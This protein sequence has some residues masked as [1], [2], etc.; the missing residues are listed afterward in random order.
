MAGRQL[1]NRAKKS[2]VTP[3]TDR[4]QARFRQL[5]DENVDAIGQG[6]VQ[7]AS[8]GNYN[9]AQLLLRFSGVD[10]DAD[11]GSAAEDDRQHARIFFL[12]MVER[13]VAERPDSSHEGDKSR[14]RVP[15][16]LH[17]RDRQVCLKGNK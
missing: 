7:K 12:E 1:S 17:R 10:P 16:D 5:L 2:G 13:M 6:L 3:Q 9:A 14:A 8:E 11:F 4:I 15:V